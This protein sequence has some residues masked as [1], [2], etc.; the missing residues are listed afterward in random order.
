MR[1]FVIGLNQIKNKVKKAKEGLGDK[2]LY[3]FD[4]NKRS[5]PW[6][7]TKDPYVIWLSE[8]ILQQTQVVQGTP[9]F[10]KFIEEFPTL[11]DLAQSSE[12]KVLKLWQGLGYYSRA[13]NMYETSKHIFY[14]LSGIFP[15][16]YN[17]L[18][19]LKGVGDYTASAIA[20]IAYNEP[21][22]VVDGNVVRVISRLFKV[23]QPFD[24]AEGK[25]NIKELAGQILNKKNPAEHN[26]GMMELG[27]LVCRP[28]NP[29]CH[30]CPIEEHCLARKDN[31]INNYPV[32]GK[33]TKTRVRYFNFVVP[34]LPSGKTIITKRTGNDIWKNMFT[35]PLYEME[36]EISSKEFLPM[37]RKEYGD[38]ELMKVTS[39]N[40]TL[41]HQ[42]INANFYFLALKESLQ[43][44]TTNQNYD[45]QK[46]NEPDVLYEPDFK[47]K[48]KGTYQ[49]NNIFE[50]EIKSLKE[51]YPLP[52]LIT[53]CMEG[54]D[55]SIYFNS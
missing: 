45:L 31:T 9:Y 10:E 49:K 7:N 28:Q 41:S 44:Q 14:N 29:L 22:A 36:K 21:V 8:V 38:F 34:I 46:L 4:E 30:V 25:K 54:K 11:K 19:K 53:K 35:F 26:Q 16:N 39:L 51:F 27:S 32:K 37:I 50:V 47:N 5:M 33:K 55:V 23:E 17:E 3:W 52:R 18:L 48:Y 2:L 6:R 24:S 15:A 12:D 40:H 42:I 1:L 43:Y 13:R 20:S